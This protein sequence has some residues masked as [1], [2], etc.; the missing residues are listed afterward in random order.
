MSGSPHEDEALLVRARTG[1]ERALADLLL[2]YR[3]FA[4]A[5]ARAYFLVG[6]DHD[7]IVQEGMI[8]LYKAIRDYDG[9]Q[10]V[11]FHAFADLCVTRQ[12]LTAVKSATRRKH[13]PLNSYVS[14]SGPAG[15]DDA[16][17]EGDWV[18]G[19]LWS[20]TTGCDPAELVISAE[21]VRALQRHVDEALSDL[22]VEVLRLYLDGLSYQAIAERV[23]RHVK[24]VDNALQRVKRKIEL[25][26]RERSVA[27]AG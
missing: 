26:V 3:G 14:L 22:E 8:G 21:R 18:I 19:E 5:K 20:S 23:D 13:S 2:R 15:P 17:G 4:R 10:G 7:D 11:P 24:A 9:A 16:A 12:V 25:H 6:A 1:D 27:E